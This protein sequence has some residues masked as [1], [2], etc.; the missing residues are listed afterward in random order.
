M[1]TLELIP[2]KSVGI[3]CL[4]SDVRKYTHIPHYLTK[5]KE[6]DFSYESYDFYE[7]DIVVWVE[8]GR[9]ET[10]CCKN[11]CY[12]QGLNLIKMPFDEF[13]SLYNVVP[14]KSENIYLL[15]NGRGQNQ[16]VYDFDKLGLQIW[17]WRKKIVTVL[18]SNYQDCEDY[19]NIVV[20]SF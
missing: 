1:K 2:N 8:K 20:S 3:F 5:N 13:Q 14:D 10:L 12:W 19:G 4:G 6:N 15:V 16:T 7:Q 17:G 9:I 11:R 18:V